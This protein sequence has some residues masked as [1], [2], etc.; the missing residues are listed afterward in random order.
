[1]EGSST[2]NMQLTKSKMRILSLNTRN[3]VQSICLNLKHYTPLKPITEITLRS[4]EDVRFRKNETVSLA[5]S[6][7]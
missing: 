7:T 6:E 2:Q 1:M 4:Q 3:N 5:F